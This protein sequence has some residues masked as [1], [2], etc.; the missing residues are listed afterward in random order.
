MGPES[1]EKGLKAVQQEVR[2]LKGTIVAIQQNFDDAHRGVLDQ[3]TQRRADI[4]EGKAGLKGELEVSDSRVG[5]LRE[6]LA[7]AEALLEAN[8]QKIKKLQRQHKAAR[9]EIK[10]LK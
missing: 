5:G 3:I 7:E 9:E 6:Q 1:G 10:K 2:R 8:T 4:D